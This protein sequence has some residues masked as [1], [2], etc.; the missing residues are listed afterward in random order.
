[1]T[2]HQRAI[3]VIS[4]IV[5]SVIAACATPPTLPMDNAAM[6]RAVLKAKQDYGVMLVP[7]AAY[8]N[9]PL[10]DKSPPPCATLSVVRQIQAAEPATRYALD[11]AEHAVR[12]PGFGG[13]IAQ[14]SVTAGL[15]ALKAFSAISS[16]VK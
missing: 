10:C 3:L 14:T 16:S 8:V 15:A 1:M 9:L 6:Q 12:T 5:A 7:I 11:A 4:L 13:D 2:M